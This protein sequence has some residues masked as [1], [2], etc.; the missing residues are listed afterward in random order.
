MDQAPPRPQAHIYGTNGNYTRSPLLLFLSHQAGPR[1]KRSSSTSTFPSTQ[2]TQQQLPQRSQSFPPLRTFQ[3]PKSS[4]PNAV[5]GKLTRPLKGRSQISTSTLPNPDPP[6]PA[7]LTA[8][9]RYLSIT[10]YGSTA[11]GT[12]VSAA[13]SGT[14]PLRAGVP[15]KN[16]TSALHRLH[17]NYSSSTSF[18]QP[19]RISISPSGRPNPQLNDSAV[20]PNSSLMHSLQRVP[21]NQCLLSDEVL[22]TSSTTVYRHP[23]QY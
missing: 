1:I 5:P 2:A 12:R 3:H 8:S 16:M 19:R 17:T 14:K 15:L 23:G 22:D 4:W 11:S 20:T 7:P 6:N 9:I 18:P 10:L 21:V 13:D